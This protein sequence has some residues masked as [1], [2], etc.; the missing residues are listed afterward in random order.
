MK[1]E[2]TTRQYICDDF[3]NLNNLSY[4]Q[5]IGLEKRYT[6]IVMNI[7]KWN[8]VHRGNPFPYGKIA[9]AYVQNTLRGDGMTLK[10]FKEEYVLFIEERMQKLKQ[11]IV[12]AWDN[13]L[14]LKTEMNNNSRLIAEQITECKCG[15]KIKGNQH[16]IY[17]HCQRKK[18]I[19]WVSECN[20]G[21]AFIPKAKIQ[22]VRLVEN[23]NEPAKLVDEDDKE[24]LQNDNETENSII[25]EE[26]E[27]IT[28][29]INKLLV[30]ADNEIVDDEVLEVM[31]ENIVELEDEIMNKTIRCLCGED[32]NMKNIEHHF[33]SSDHDFRMSMIEAAQEEY[34]CGEINKSLITFKQIQEES[35]TM[36]K[37]KIT[38]RNLEIEAIYMCECGLFMDFKAYKSHLRHE[39]HIEKMKKISFINIAKQREEEEEY[40]SNENIVLS[41]R[42][43]IAVC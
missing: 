12:K 42:E 43:P 11:H 2:K 13:Y 14:V 8:M 39:S 34:E 20:N 3:K 21:I 23:D 29:D 18:H 32:Y 5:L 35:L 25:T 4:K 27:D 40:K 37:T 33:D 22:S 6:T 16:F 10:E 1:N 24:V 19:K 7:K 31:E 41:I 26:Y 9:N 30:D 38:I 17:Q 28:D 15:S 36:S